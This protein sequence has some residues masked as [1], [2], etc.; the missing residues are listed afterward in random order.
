MSRL[1]GGERAR[2]RLQLSYLYCIYLSVCICRWKQNA[3]RMCV[4]GIH[5]RVSSH[6]FHIPHSR[7]GKLCICTR[8]YLLDHCEKRLRETTAKKKSLATVPLMFVGISDI[9]I[10]IQIRIRILWFVFW[11]TDPA[12]DPAPDSD[13]D[14]VLFGSGFQDVNKK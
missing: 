11:I 4:K 6:W 7:I 8:I 2:Q 5:S 13:T 14:P 12:L 1:T 10:R 9:L 3:G